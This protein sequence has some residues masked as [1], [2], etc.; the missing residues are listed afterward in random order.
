MDGLIHCNTLFHKGTHSQSL[1]LALSVDH[2]DNLLGGGVSWGTLTV[3]PGE[4][5]TH[6]TA[7]ESADIHF[8]KWNLELSRIQ[9]VVAG[10]SVYGHFS[11]Q[12]ADRKVLDGSESFY[13][14]GVNG[15]RAYPL[16]EGSGSRGWIGQLE[17]RYQTPINLQPYAFIDTGYSPNGG[18]DEDDSRQISGAGLGLR[19]SIV[20]IS[21]DGA[22]AWKMSG[23][24]S[25]SD[26]SQR[27]PRFWFNIGYQF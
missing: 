12:W 5:S 11:G 16:G 20:G 8:T 25:Q 7:S 14:G 9:H 15:V 22:V 3:T 4:L 10:L 23:G 13:L 1:P 26:S 6:Q 24:D 18:I 17:M 27:D 19:Y 2:R 21:M